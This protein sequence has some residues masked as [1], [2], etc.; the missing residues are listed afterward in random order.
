MILGETAI[1][2]YHLDRDALREIADQ[3]GPRPEVLSLLSL[4]KRSH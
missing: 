3:I 1:G 2:V 4:R